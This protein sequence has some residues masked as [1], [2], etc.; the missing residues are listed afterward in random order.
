MRL[1][2]L[3]LVATVSTAIAQDA[4]KVE[5]KWKF[6]KGESLRY[7]MTYSVDAS[8]GGI[9]IKQ[10]M[11]FAFTMGVQEIAENGVATIETRYDR[12]KLKMSGVMEAEYDSDAPKKEEEKKEGEEGMPDIAGMMG[13]MFGAMVGKSVTMKMNPRGE[14]LEVKGFDKIMEEMTKALGDEAQGEMLKQM[15][16]EDQMKQMFQSGW[17]M[18]PD[19]PVA[20]GD[21]WDH[22]M[23]TKMAGVG[24]ITMKNKLT[25]KE[26][27]NGGKDA[28]IKVDTKIEG[29]PDDE[30]GMVELTDGKMDSEIG[31]SLEKGR[32]E[33]MT[34]TMTMKMAA[35]GQEFEVS[36]ALTMKLA[37]KKDR[38]EH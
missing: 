14:I 30:G 29:K 13:K 20:K 5:L 25:L 21:T 3:A 11:L 1:L 27:R 2:A 10:E 4:D 36:A 8:V 9:D 12:V 31:W 17:A 35:G 18:L 19:K 16:S 33:S 32:M 7:E 37:P 24:T 15:M 23:E 34:G 22:K 6:T 26:L 28:V 38:K